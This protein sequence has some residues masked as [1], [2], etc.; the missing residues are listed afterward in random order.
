M[1]IIKNKYQKLI[2]NTAKEFKGSSGELIID[3]VMDKICSV[4]AMTDYEIEERRQYISELVHNLI[5]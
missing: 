3:I 2:E 5:R 4:D 1:S